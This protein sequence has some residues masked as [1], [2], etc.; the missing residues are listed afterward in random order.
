MGFYDFLIGGS[1]DSDFIDYE[2]TR[3]GVTVNTLT[4]E[5]PGTNPSG[6]DY[7][8]D[9]TFSVHGNVIPEPATLSLLLVGGLT[10]ARRRR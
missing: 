9:V 1:P 3:F 5:T 6:T 4:F 10:L 2:I 7:T 8:L